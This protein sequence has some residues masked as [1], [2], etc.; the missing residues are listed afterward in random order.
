MDNHGSYLT[1]DFLQ[2]CEE[3]AILVFTFP[4]H[5]THLLQPLDKKPFLQFKHFHRKAVN[6]AASHGYEAYGKRE[7]LDNLP[8][9]R[10]N[11]LKSRTIQSGFAESGILPFNPGPVLE[12]MERQAVPIPNIEI[13]EGDRDA[14]GNSIPLSQSSESSSP[15]NLQRLRKHIDTARLAL[16]GIAEA[17]DHSSPNLHRRLNKIFNGSIVQAELNAQREEDLN[18][19]LRA[20]QRRQRPKT[21]RQVLGGLSTN[22]SMTVRD[23]KRRIEK[24][25]AD[26]VRKQWRKNPMGGTSG[27]DK[28]LARAD[29][30]VQ[31]SRDD[32]GMALLR[33]DELFYIDSGPYRGS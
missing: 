23:A 8:S 11:A 12:E 25:R 28:A 15:K 10:A 30:E 24:R 31:P 19:H 20:T 13:W 17:L 6:W 18:G 1:Y 14:R 22:G 29:Q 3:R 27:G 16:D 7:F 9:V 2:Y 26:E 32:R 33:D 21:R 5:S 4:P